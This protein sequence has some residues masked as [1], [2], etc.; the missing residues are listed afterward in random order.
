[1]LLSHHDSL[2]MEWRIGSTVTYCSLIKHAV[3]RARIQH[4]E[5]AAKG[6]RFAFFEKLCLIIWR[7]HISGYNESWQS[8]AFFSLISND[9]MWDECSS[10]GR[11]GLT[12]CMAAPAPLHECLM[13]VDKCNVE[14]EKTLWTFLAHMHCIYEYSL[15]QLIWGCNKTKI[16][17]FGVV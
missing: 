12:P 4:S 15:L 11:V 9:C 2:V 7:I 8:T 1:M 13:F 3:P 16:P 10:G 5:L 6:G 14:K 17:K